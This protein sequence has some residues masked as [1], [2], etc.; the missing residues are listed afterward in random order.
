MAPASADARFLAL[1]RRHCL[2]AALIGAISGAVEA[3][4]GLRQAL[5]LLFGELADA[6]LLAATQRALVEETF[7]VYGFA[8]PAS[9]HGI[10]VENIQ[11]AGTAAS[12][13]GDALARRLLRHALGATGARLLRRVLP[14]A[15]VLTSALAN[16]AVTYAIGQRAR[17]V[18]RLGRAPVGSLA[19][20]VRAFSGVDE[21]RIL[22]WSLTA[23]KRTFAT[24]RGLLPGAGARRRPRQPAATRRPRPA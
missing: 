12:L 16:A 11:L 23:A 3:L 24:L 2:R 18:A 19:D 9:V 17:A 14:L 22:D 5:S 7:G 15:P 1:L 20:A 10:F 21:R 13:T 8:L 4:P 6:A